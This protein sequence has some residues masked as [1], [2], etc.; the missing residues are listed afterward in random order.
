MTIRFASMTIRSASVL[1]RSASVP[2]YQRMQAAIP[3]KSTSARAK[4]PAENLDCQVAGARPFFG[5]WDDDAVF[6]G[7]FLTFG[8]TAI[9]PCRDL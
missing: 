5:C 4:M 9:C 8:F 2:N 7:E 3:L 6:R 1:I